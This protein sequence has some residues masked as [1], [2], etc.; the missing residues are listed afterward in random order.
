MNNTVNPLYLATGTLRVR[1]R[2][3]WHSGG[4]EKGP[5]G[6]YPHLKDENGYPVYPD[7]QIHGDLRMAAEWLSALDP[8]VTADRIETV[9]GREGGDAAALLKVT[10][11]RL[12]DIA[13]ADDPP[14]AL[15]SVKPR[16]RIDADT[17]TVSKHMLVDREVAFLDGRELTAM[18]HLGYCK[19][20][21]DLEAAKSLVSQAAAF[22]SGFGAFRSRGY[23]RGRV[24]VEWVSPDNEKISVSP[25]EAEAPPASAAYY[26]TA[27]VHYRSK[28]VDA[29]TTQVLDSAC[30]IRPDQ[31]RGWLARTHRQVFGAWPT[32]DEMATIELPGLHPSDPQSD[33][34]GY[35]PAMTTL[36]DE[37]GAVSDRWG[38]GAAG[39][40]AEESGKYLH[41]KS[42]PL[43]SGETVA[44]LDGRPIRLKAPRREHRFR[45]AMSKAGT[46]ETKTDGLFVQ[47]LI[48]AGA[49]F[50]GVIRFH[51]PDTD[52][53]RRAWMLLSRVGPVI[54]GTLFEPKTAAVGGESSDPAS[55]PYLV[56][57]PISLTDD[58]LGRQ[59]G[60][61]DDQILVAGVRRYNTMLR[62]PRRTR[63]SIDIGSVLTGPVAG[64]TARW[65]GWGRTVEGHPAPEPGREAPAP[66]GTVDRPTQ[67]ISKSEAITRAQAGI[68]REYLHPRRTAAEIR[69]H[70]DHRI[71]KYG[72]KGEVNLKALL[73]K[74]RGRIEGDDLAPMRQFIREYL[75]DLAVHLYNQEKK[76]G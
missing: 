59:G 4:G 41:H 60:S 39:P 11:L 31:L 37:S 23:G 19:S 42:H 56:T 66:E 33:I 7:T 38:R 69:R 5:F 32:P 22:L 2:G 35:P 48:R 3:Y 17:R 49:V 54:K 8:D 61:G 21:S 36:R 46:F 24:S 15:F 6:F 27:R 64:R 12:A 16:I 9:F 72:T 18:V 65:S 13:D 26:L 75:E 53:A 45:N 55:G 25:S 43:A 47:E 74:I 71:E 62:R 70:L 34:V 76:T 52:F 50:G 67:T 20:G 10:D 57:A 73:E 28:G 44:S 1:A 58:R 30:W 29:G 63:I 51:Q 40:D 14:E 68:L